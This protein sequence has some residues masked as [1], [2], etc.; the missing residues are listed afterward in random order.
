[1]ADFGEYGGPIKKILG[2]QSLTALDGDNVSTI[3]THEDQTG[4]I[5]D[6]TVLMIITTTGNCYIEIGSAAT[7]SSFALTSTDSLICKIRSQAVLGVWGNGGT[8]TIT[9]KKVVC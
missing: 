2:S 9:V 8:P 4:N 7:T 6:S 3:I 5:G 1:M